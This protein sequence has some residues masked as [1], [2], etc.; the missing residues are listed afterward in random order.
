V[1][2]AA[3]VTVRPKVHRLRDVQ[4]QQLRAVR[5]RRRLRLPQRLNLHSNH[6]KPRL[7][8]NFSR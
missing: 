8:M 4:Q 2:V 6:I 5:P 1:P 7:H 3:R